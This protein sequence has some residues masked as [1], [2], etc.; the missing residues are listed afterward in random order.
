MTTET[1][2]STRGR[3]F[4]SST[5]IEAIRFVRETT[6]GSEIGQQV[7]NQGLLEELQSHENY[8]LVSRMETIAQNMRSVTYAL[9]KLRADQKS[10]EL[11][12]AYWLNGWT[13]EKQESY[14]V[15]DRSLRQLTN[16]LKH[17]NNFVTDTVTD[18][19][20]QCP[21]C[22]NS[23]NN[24]RAD[25]QYCSGKCKQSAYRKSQQ[26]IQKCCEIEGLAK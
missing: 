11:K 23:F 8:W 1:E 5:G 22:G 4:T 9:K 20:R 10:K 16:E 19:T 2:V 26:N 14:S 24:K 12:E 17:F 21:V 6:N 13:Y 15:F 25:A 3:H 18:D 7:I